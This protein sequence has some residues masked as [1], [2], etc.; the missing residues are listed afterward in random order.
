[1]V[2]FS[3]LGMLRHYSISI[4]R[5]Q[6]Y[7]AFQTN[8]FALNAAV[9]DVEAGDEITRQNAAPALKMT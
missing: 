3:E 9:K 7:I 6:H 2:N 1:V 5:K 8:L 4:K